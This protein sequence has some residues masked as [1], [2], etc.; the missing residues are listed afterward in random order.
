MPIFE[1]EC[2]KCKTRFEFLV[3]GSEKPACPKCGGKRLEKLISAFGAISEKP[4]GCSHGGDCACSHGGGH[5]AH[6]ACGGCGCG[7]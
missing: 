4:R 3:R 1:Y 2:K 5:S 7:R 6:C